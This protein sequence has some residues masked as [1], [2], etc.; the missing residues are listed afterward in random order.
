MKKMP[1]AESEKK[2]ASARGDVKAKKKATKKKKRKKPLSMLLM[3]GFVRPIAA[4]TQD[5]PVCLY[6]CQEP[7]QLRCGDAVCRKCLVLM[8]HAMDEGLVCP[9]CRTELCTGFANSINT[10]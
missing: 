6:P 8:Q 1:A 5:C 9:V 7:L 10:E 3:A 2:P 4:C